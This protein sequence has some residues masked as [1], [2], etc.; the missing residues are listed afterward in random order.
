MGEP[1]QDRSTRAFVQNVRRGHHE[2]AVE[3]PVIRWLA[4][5]FEE[6][7]LAK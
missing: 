3:E 7:A 2:L 4:V 5:A 1:K 6:P